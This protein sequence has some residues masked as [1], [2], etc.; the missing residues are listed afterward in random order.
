[1][2]RSDCGRGDPELRSLRHSAQQEVRDP[3]T[4][5]TSDGIAGQPAKTK[6]RTRRQNGP[7]QVAA[8]HHSGLNGVPALDLGEVV[9]ERAGLG[10]LNDVV[11]GSA[12]SAQVADTNEGYRNERGSF[13]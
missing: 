9:H 8:E 11:T 12:E 1:M 3:V 2:V 4:A 5:L 7:R 10:D 13:A 6:I